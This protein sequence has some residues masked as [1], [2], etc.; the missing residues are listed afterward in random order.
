[1]TNE[2][3]MGTSVITV[4]VSN[5]PSHC[6]FAVHENLLRKS[7]H[8]FEKALGGPWRES[9]QKMINLP[10]I[11]I[12]AM[13]TYVQWLYSGRL[14]ITKDDA[15]E[16]IQH[17]S[18]WERLVEG[19]LFGNYIQDTDY[20]DSMVDAMVEQI[21]SKESEKNTPAMEYVSIVFDASAPSSPIRDF[22]TDV[23]IWAVDHSFWAK[24]SEE[25]QKSDVKGIPWKDC[26]S[27]DY[28]FKVLAGITHRLE[29]KTKSPFLK[30][31]MPCR[32]HCH[33]IEQ[34]YKT[35]PP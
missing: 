24:A 29:R 5:E 26:L 22:F 15:G 32:Y 9:Q 7:S 17:A 18:K 12:S 20:K 33:G 27:Q 13:K 31:T 10:D 21:G 19:Y 1:M 6:D 34:C 14:H 4:R 23:G 8:F 25:H 28:C 11:S 16:L 35:K 3:R 30:R 2:F